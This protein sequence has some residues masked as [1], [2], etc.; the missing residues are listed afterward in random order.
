MRPK[1]PLSIFQNIPKSLLPAPAPPQWPTA[2]ATS[3]SELY[4]QKFEFDLASFTF[5]ES[6]N[7]AVK[8]TL[9]GIFKGK[10]DFSYDA[11]YMGIKC[12]MSSLES[13]HTVYITLQ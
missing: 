12:S 8:R 5:Y 7:H 10:P 13:N 9:L 3:S 11:Y 2:K 4:Q 6:V 1:E